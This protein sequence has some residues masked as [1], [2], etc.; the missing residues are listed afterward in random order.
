ME[1]VIPRLSLVWEHSLTNT[2]GHNRN[3][4]AGRSLR[5]WV[6]YQGVHSLLDLLSRDPEEF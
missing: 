5:E 1:N 3:T 4:E 6:P 2:L